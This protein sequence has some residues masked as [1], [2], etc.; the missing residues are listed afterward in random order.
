[1]KCQECEND[2]EPG[3]LYFSYSGLKWS[4]ECKKIKTIIGWRKLYSI[5]KRSGIQYLNGWIC[6]NCKYVTIKYEL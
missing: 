5:D 4:Y 2:M 1:M 6:K 3:C